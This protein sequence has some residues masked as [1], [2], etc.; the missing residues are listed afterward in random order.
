M[1]ESLKIETW[2][3]GLDPESQVLKC[4]E[5]AAELFEAVRTQE[6]KGHA[7]TAISEEVADLM[8]AAANLGA[9][10]GIDLKRALE[11]CHEKNHEKGRV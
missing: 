6:R 5:E 9:M 1:S 3:T 7:Y 11:R 8:Q 10:Y 2:D 4:F